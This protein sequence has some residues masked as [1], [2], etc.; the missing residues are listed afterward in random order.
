MGHRCNPRPWTTPCPCTVEKS[1][2]QTSAR[3]AASSI[4]RSP[5]TSREGCSTHPRAGWNLAA[6]SPRVDLGRSPAAGASSSTTE[7][8]CAP[9]AWGGGKSVLSAWRGVLLVV[10][11]LGP[12]HPLSPRDGTV[13]KIGQGHCDAQTVVA[14]RL[15]ESSLPL[16]HGGPPQHVQL[17]SPT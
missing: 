13:L 9:A 3:D 11:F 10:L 16:S 15:S 2:P 8:N 14:W 1:T 4:L 6:R 17:A 7:K 12:G 5:G